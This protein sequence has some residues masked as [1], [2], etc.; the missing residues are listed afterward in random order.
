M[1]LP[2]GTFFQV[3]AWVLG[4]FFAFWPVLILV[5]LR[6]RGN[7][8]FR[9]TAAWGV[10]LVFWLVSVLVPLPNKFTLFPEPFTTILFWLTGIALI[11]NQVIRRLWQRRGLLA[12]ADRAASVDDLHRP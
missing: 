9:M 10:L 7:I 4:F 8:L 3:I 2:Y 12:K 5:P 11:T 6:R 1:T